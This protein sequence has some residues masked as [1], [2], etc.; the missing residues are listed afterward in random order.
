MRL[1]LCK[2]AS[3][4]EIQKN[5]I[6]FFRDNL[7]ATLSTTADPP[8]SHFLLIWPNFKPTISIVIR[9]YKPQPLSID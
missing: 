9:V 7:S 5:W 4:K 2:L 1:P 3:E 6:G 8:F